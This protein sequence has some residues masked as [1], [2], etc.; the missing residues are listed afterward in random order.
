MKGSF[1]IQ[2]KIVE[3]RR[4]MRIIL[5]LDHYCRGCVESLERATFLASIVTTYV[6]ISRVSRG[7]GFHETLLQAS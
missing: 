1:D 7:W 6:A 5:Y 2:L 4:Y 3:V